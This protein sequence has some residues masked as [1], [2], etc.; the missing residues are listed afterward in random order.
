MTTET[1]RRERQPVVD[2]RATSGPSWNALHEIAERQQ[3]LFTIEQAGGAGFSAQLLS[4]HVA[5]GNLDRVRRGI[6]RLTRFPAAERAQEDLVV[7]WL[8]SGRAGVFSHE[9][10]LQLHQ[11]SDVLPA[12]IHLTVPASWEKR[13]VR[14]PEGVELYTADVSAAETTWVGAVPV[15]APARS[16]VDVALAHGDAAV[17]DRAVRQAL[18]RNDA[19]LVEVAPAVAY[20]AG[21][22]PAEVAVGSWLVDVVAGSPKTAL[23]ADWRTVAEDFA[24]A[25]GADLRSAAYD[26][27]R[28]QLSLEL[29]WPLAALATKPHYES[30]RADAAKV[31]G[32]R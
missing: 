2:D 26:R 10:A 20:L 31:F 15:T 6:Y 1:E 11:L 8:W 9:T 27:D 13:R 16:I 19:S 7:V 4:K 17:I 21:T 23:P 25:H 12:R 32:W 3:G 14:P 18:R 29:A 5:S 24:R 30:V 28:R 22:P